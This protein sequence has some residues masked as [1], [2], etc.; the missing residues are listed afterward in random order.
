MVRKGDWKLV[1]YVGHPPQLFNIAEDPR[2]IVDLSGQEITAKIQ[3]DLE[4]ELRGIVD[5]EAASAQAF[6][7]QAMRIKQLG[8]VNVIRAKAEIGFTPAPKG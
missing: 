5:P 3:A 1:Y 4:A 8:G 7:D 6:A 2:E